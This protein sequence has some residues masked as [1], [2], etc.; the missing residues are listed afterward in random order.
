MVTEPYDYAGLFMVEQTFPIVKDGKFLGIAGVDRSLDGMAT[1][2]ATERPYPDADIFLISGRGRVIVATSNES[3]R[4]QPI[5]AVPG[6]SPLLSQVYQAS[7]SRLAAA[8]AQTT[9]DPETGARLYYA[10]KRIP[11]GDWTLLITAP[12]S[13]ILAQATDVM[14]ITIAGL[15]VI[16]I[17]ILLLVIGAVRYVSGRLRAAASAADRVADNDLTVH[18]G[19]VSGDGIGDMLRSVDRMV[20]SLREDV[21]RR[22]ALAVDLTSTVT[23][24]RSAAEVQAASVGDFGASTSQV[25]AATRE[26]SATSNE[27]ARTVSEVVDA[28]TETAD[29]AGAGK[30]SLAELEASMRTLGE[31]TAA[32]SAKL[33]VISEKAS[34]IGSVVLTITKVADQTNLLSLNA[35]IEAEKAGEAGRGFAVVAR[36]IRRLADQTAV[37]TLDIGSLVSEMQSSVSSGVME[38]DRFS[39][40]VRTSIAEADAVGRGFERILDQVQSLTPRLASVDEGMQSQA[41]GA[42]SINDAMAQLAEVAQRTSDSLREL[43]S[44]AERLRETVGVVEAEVARFRID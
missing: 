34:N 37:A 17:G 13:T 42:Q 24:I 10:A 35:A 7:A 6:W 33:G 2:I 44:A 32:I 18:L 11:S 3:Y 23:S 15:A 20:E 31:A 36:E 22:R 21:N 1:R 5:E 14:W 40:R 27:L 43:D 4:L 30:G 38:M 26:I 28:T 19:D 16:V 29:A 9:T 39:E 41:L 12:E 8:G 25:A